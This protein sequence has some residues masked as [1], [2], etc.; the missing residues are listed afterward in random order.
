MNGVTKCILLSSFIITSACASS[1]HT[2]QSMP[3]KH[4][5]C[6]GVEEWVTNQELYDMVVNTGSNAGGKG[7][8]I[9]RKEEE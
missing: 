2:K 9:I 1:P 7:C 6:N 4:V 8:E 5:R 3:M